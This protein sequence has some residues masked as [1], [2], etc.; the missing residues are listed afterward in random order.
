M[1]VCNEVIAA[2]TQELEYR[3]VP[4][5]GSN[6]VI[7]CR[8]ISIVVAMVATFFLTDID[9]TSST[10]TP[11]MSDGFNWP[12]AAA[13]YVQQ[14]D[15]KSV[16]ANDPSLPLRIANATRKSVVRVLLGTADTIS[17]WKADPEE[18]LRDMRRMLDDARRNDVRLILSNYLSEPAVEALAGREYPS[19]P[20][21]QRDLTAP[22]SPAWNGLEAWTAAVVSVLHD[23]PAVYSWE[24]TNEPSWMLGMDNGAVDI[25][26][27][28]SFLDHFQKKLHTYGGDVVN[29]GGLPL[30]DP[31]RLTDTQLLLATRH[32]DVLDHHLYSDVSG[33]GTIVD[34]ATSVE[35]YAT[36]IERLHALGRR[37]PAMLGEIGTRP[38]NWFSWV[39]CEARSRGWLALPWGYDSWDEYHFS[40]GDRFDVLAHPV[41]G[42]SS[43]RSDILP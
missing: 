16:S 15:Q 23:H 25:N 9:T 14:W 34:A 20:T 31:S 26:Q 36:Y 1:R 13:V 2:E 3:E 42:C 22:Y 29:M 35:E 40:V 33:D 11:M 19:W 5:G 32:V 39:M 43:H 12:N 10:D 6:R 18:T 38:N 17:R 41:D 21:A 7:G 4:A 24:V 30:F 27:G 37:I 28:L 8:R